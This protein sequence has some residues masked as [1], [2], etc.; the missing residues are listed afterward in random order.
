MLVWLVALFFIAPGNI[1]SG[2]FLF[3]FYLGYLLPEAGPALWHRLRSHP[4]AGLAL[5]L[6]AVAMLLGAHC[7]HKPLVEVGLL[8]EGL[9]GALVVAALVYGP[10]R[11]VYRFLDLPLT[12]FY[13]RVSYSFYLLHLFTLF[14]VAQ[15]FFWLLPAPMLLRFAVGF[16]VLL[17]LV[18]T[19]A[20]SPLCWL[21]YRFVEQP[22]IQL[23]K[24]I[25]QRLKTKP[26]Q[27]PSSLP[28]PLRKPSR[29]KDL[30]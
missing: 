24:Q 9:G 30:V 19:I 10:D 29:Q 25:C 4:T 7:L 23:S 26:G 14:L 27:N 2:R 13:G 1:T 5:T 6:G 17:W 20:V 16:G 18:S 21:S 11:S 22:F 3:M 28:E 8:C 12:R 15:V